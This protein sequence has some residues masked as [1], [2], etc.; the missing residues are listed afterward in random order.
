MKK[1]LMVGMSMAIPV[2]SNSFQNILRPA[3]LHIDQY[4]EI[5][6]VYNQHVADYFNKLTPQERI[7]IYYM[8][9]ASLPGNRIAADQSHRD[10]LKIQDI[11]AF[12]VQHKDRVLSQAMPFDNALFIQQ[13]TTYLVYLWSNHSPYFLR[14]HAD[15]KRT[16][17]RLGLSLLNQDNIVKLLNTLSYPHAQQIIESLAPSLF[18][19][20]VEPS[21][22]VPDNIEKS[23]VNF[24]GPGFTDQDF[25]NIDSQIQSKQ[26]VYFYIDIQN[27]KRVP[28][29]QQY[30]V[31]EK[32]GE[33]LS[34]AVYWLHKAADLARKN[35]KQFDKH[36]VKS[37]DYL[38]EYFTTGDEEI[39]K[40]HSIE[41]LK[42]NSKIDY[43]FG[44]IES[45]PD[46]KSYR[47]MF[48]AD[49]TI[50]AVDMQKIN[51]LLPKLEA[52][53]PF[54]A[55]YKR[56]NL[57]TSASMPNASINVKAFTAGSLGPLNIT[58]AYCLPNYEE[59][60]TQHGSKQIIYHTEK[61]VGELLDPEVYH[62][63]FNA[64]KHFDW[65]AHYDPNFSLDTDLVML[66]VILHETL[67]HGSGALASHTFQEGDPLVIDGKQHQ[68]GDVI[69][70]TSNN[71]QQFLSGYDQTMEE[72]RAEIIA[73]LS[74]IIS[75]DDLVK[76]GLYKQWPDHI[77]K[78]KLIEMNIVS[79]MRFGLNRLR[80]LP[81]NATEIT[82]DHAR[83]NTVL[84]NYLIAHG[85]VN[86][87]EEPVVVKGIQ[88]TIVD[89]DVVDLE[90]TIAAIQ[91]LA[92]LVQEIKSTANRN[93]AIWLVQTY[94]TKIA[95]KDHMRYLK[96]NQKAAIG[97]IKVVAMLYPF[98]E[99][100][101]DDNGQ[102]ID[103]ATSWPESFIDQYQRFN[104]LALQTL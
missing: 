93:K 13:T 88:H 21:G 67:G 3:P 102:I 18:D 58:L 71:I 41:W 81:D 51:Q 44:F 10:A 70:V 100:I 31:S 49:V 57:D 23:A 43:N 66:H 79:M 30:S 27:G 46:P 7:F 64:K 98:Y 45:Y 22:T 84:N 72:L 9:R 55:A 85:G 48:Q 42:S 8:M 5:A 2:S 52:Q 86:V 56:K 32:Y 77:S 99:P 68:I 104:N 47:G 103:I 19:Q 39:F 6:V 96:E 11:F 15:E 94:G 76:I 101:L 14:E 89:I 78:E 16:P 28:R 73:L 83:A 82:G 91:E 37:L 50:K 1:L 17:H 25:K 53:L 62:R 59:I 24:Y 97:A 4:N 26:N 36:I 95:N 61:S 12:I 40:K 90:K 35:S 29:Y 87:S 38:I 54:D 65:S 92:Q 80:S 69:P 34:V 63:L 33:E 74:S 20:S 60:R 75:Y